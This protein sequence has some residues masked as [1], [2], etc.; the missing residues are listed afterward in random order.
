[1]FEKQRMTVV[2]PHASS[3]KQRM[4]EPTFYLTEK[5]GKLYVIDWKKSDL[6]YYANNIPVRPTGVRLEFGDG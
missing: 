6:H 2:Y 4:D 1:M 3:K 5:V